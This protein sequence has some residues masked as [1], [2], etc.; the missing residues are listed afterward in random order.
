METNRI[1]ILAS[2]KAQVAKV[3]SVDISDVQEEAQFSD[4]GIT[5]IELIDIFIKL[6]KEFGA[7]F[8][9]DDVTH[10]SCHNLADN[11]LKSMG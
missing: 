9:A 2:V 10:M 3:L 8:K 11:L 7:K 4:L 5:S 6:E 1:D